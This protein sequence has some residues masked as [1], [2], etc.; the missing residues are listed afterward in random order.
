MGV[1]AVHVGGSQWPKPLL[2]LYPFMAYTLHIVGQIDAGN[3][4]SIQASDKTMAWTMRPIWLSGTSQG[5]E[6]P[7]STQ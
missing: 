5:M 6:R 7:R 4:R 2:R 1:E 3:T